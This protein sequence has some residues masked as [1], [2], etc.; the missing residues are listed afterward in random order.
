MVQFRIPHPE[1]SMYAKFSMQVLRL[2]C[3]ASEKRI[4]S[5]NM[6]AYLEQGQLMLR[7]DSYTLAPIEDQNV[8]MSGV[9]NT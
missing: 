5:A 7:N 4:K 1:K 9:N 6:F 2:V 8:S 3:P